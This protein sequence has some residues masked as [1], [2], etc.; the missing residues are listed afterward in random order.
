MNRQVKKPTRSGDGPTFEHIVD[1]DDEISEDR[2]ED[3]ENFADGE[4]SVPDDE[5]M[6]RGR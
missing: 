1:E 6:R 4:F 2:L 3:E 5:D